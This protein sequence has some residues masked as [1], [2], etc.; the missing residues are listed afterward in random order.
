[1]RIT[2]LGC[3]NSTGVPMVG[4]DW[5]ACDP[6]NRRNRRRR[7][8]IAVEQGG[9]RL[10][11]DTPPELREQCLDA[12]IDR[13]DGVIYT[14]AHADHCHGIDDL[15]AF[16]IRADRDLPVYATEATLAALKERFG[17]VFEGAARHGGIWYRPKLDPVTVTGKFSVGAIAVTPFAQQHGRMT[18]LGL[19]FGRFAYSTDVN[20]LP[21]SAFAALAGVE[22]WLVDCIRAEPSPGHAHLAQTLEWI[23]R[24]RPKRAILTHMSG[25]LDYQTLC[26]R[27]P[28]GI[29]PAYDG[30]VIE[31]P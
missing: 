22:T 30:M 24:V 17:Y 13:I 21:E 3:G 5:G 15:K 12:G 31:V 2:V 14:H 16:N 20:A 19:R 9:S 11:V 7:V 8:A 28:E 4:P 26:D 23:A 18:T 27:L 6:A 25:D 10:I 1:M 29:E